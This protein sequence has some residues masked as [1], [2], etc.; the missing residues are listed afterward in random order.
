MVLQTDSHRNC[1]T[2]CVFKRLVTI[3]RFSVADKQ[4]D[5][6]LHY[7]VLSYIALGKFVQTLQVLRM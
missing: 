2:K 3:D 5:C 4:H 7:F 6:S 1:Y